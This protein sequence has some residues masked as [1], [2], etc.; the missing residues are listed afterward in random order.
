LSRSVGLFVA[1]CT[2]CSGH[3]GN[4]RR[5]PVF[6]LL[7]IMTALASIL[8]AQ[9]VGEYEVKAAF[10]YKFAS[11]VE[12]PSPA[13]TAPPCIGVLGEDPFGAI[14]DRVV[15]GKFV[16]G[17]P[18]RIRRFRSGQNIAECRVLFISSSEKSRFRSVLESLRLPIL[19]V[20]DTPG[21]CQSGGIITMEVQN[22]RVHL[23]IN[24]EAAGKAKLRLSSKLLSVA[25][26]VYGGG[27]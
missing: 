9:D 1:A 2:V 23:L 6:R 22:D 7:L 27:R 13:D 20:G 5:S 16:N 19:T 21:F 18:L 14:L 4:L 17:R 15:Q 12:W 10:L 26:I 24:P 8:A 3:G 25:T 11:F